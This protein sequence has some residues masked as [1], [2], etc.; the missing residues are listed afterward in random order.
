MASDALASFLKRTDQNGPVA[1]NHP[2]LGRCWVWL[3]ART[4]KGY[5]LFRGTTSHRWAYKYF[6]GPVPVGLQL[7]HYACDYIGCCNPYHVR[8]VTAR[9]N[10]LRGDTQTSRRLAQTHCVH[11]HEFTAP[12]TRV[13]RNGTRNCRRCAADAYRRAVSERSHSRRST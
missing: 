13:R 1:R 4:I 6:I 3:G 11:G 9:E 12:N 8:P 10:L 2:E 5:G 7:D